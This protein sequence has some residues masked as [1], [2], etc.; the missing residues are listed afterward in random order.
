LLRLFLKAALDG[1]LKGLRYW[2]VKGALSYA[3]VFRYV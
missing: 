1:T 3:L 2:G